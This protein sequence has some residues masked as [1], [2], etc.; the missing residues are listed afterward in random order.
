GCVGCEQWKF[1]LPSGNYPERLQQLHLLIDDVDALRRD[2][3]G[4]EESANRLPEE[5]P[6][7]PDPDRSTRQVCEESRFDQALKIDRA[8]VSIRAQGPDEFRDLLRA[9]DAGAIAPLICIDRYQADLQPA[10]VNDDP[11]LP[12]DKPV[13]FS[14]IG[15]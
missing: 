9:A 14:Q 12:L 1:D 7:P 5:I 6:F 10:Q 8:I 4:V 11:V 15:R 2:D 13:D 3:L